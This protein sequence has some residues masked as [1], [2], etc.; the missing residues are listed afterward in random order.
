MDHNPYIQ[1]SYAGERLGR[2]IVKFLPAALAGNG[3][4][5]LPDLF[6]KNALGKESCVIEETIMRLVKMAHVAL[7]VSAAYKGPTKNDK[8][9]LAA[10]VF[11][12]AS[13]IAPPFHIAYIV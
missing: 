13:G 6:D 10:A 7:P 3:R 5:L 2:L 1:V 11:A 4:A 9:A 12:L 8:K